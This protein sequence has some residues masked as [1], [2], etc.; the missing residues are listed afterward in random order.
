MKNHVLLVAITGIILTALT[1]PS[2]RAKEET[3]WY[4]ENFH[5]TFDYMALPFNGWQASTIKGVPPIREGNAGLVGLYSYH[6]QF[7][8]YVEAH[9]DGG[10][11]ML[12]TPLTNSL[13]AG[14][15]GSVVW[16]QMNDAVPWY[17]MLRVSDGLTSQWLYADAPAS[18]K[19]LHWVQRMVDVQKAPWKIFAATGATEQAATLTGRATGLGF[20]AR[21]M[22]G[23]A[24]LDDVL[25]YEVEQH[26]A[27]T[28]PE[29]QFPWLLTAAVVILCLAVVIFLPR[30]LRFQEKAYRSKNRSRRK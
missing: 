3:P 25:L 16:Y 30:L 29:T 18:N 5:W 17:L 21:R 20:M 22:Q 2:L 26:L 19:P 23:I 15:V 27:I 10:Y 8:G 28:I 9:N 14:Q 11:I 4:V 24:R 7:K 12:T 1:A 13:P 6:D